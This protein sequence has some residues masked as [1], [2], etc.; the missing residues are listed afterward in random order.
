MVDSVTM[1]EPRQILI[2]G[3]E[4]GDYQRLSAIL[5]RSSMDIHR[6][7]WSSHVL[8]LVQGMAFDVIVVGFPVT[9]VSLEQLVMAVRAET[10]PCRRTG[11]LLFA[12][13]S[14]LATARR[15]LG[16]GVNRIIR[17]DC[18]DT[19]ILSAVADLLSVAPRR[20]I[21]ASTRLVVRLDH[22]PSVLLCQTQNLSLSGMLV[23]ATRRFPHGTR[24]DFEINLPGDGEPVR[25]NAEITRTADR[26]RERVDGFGARFLSFAPA[27]RDRL[28]AFLRP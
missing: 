23:R 25:G 17:S 8:E 5:R 22:G 4:A 3:I 28:E 27:D 1:S 24:L 6:T 7:Q 13:P 16:R 18:E 2:T 26:V 14:S 9:G 12:R 19:D 15:L 11:V 21:R 10:S 20:P